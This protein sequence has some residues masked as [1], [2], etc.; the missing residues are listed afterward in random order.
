MLFRD[1]RS[2]AERLNGRDYNK[3][4][5]KMQA[6][7]Y[8]KALESGKF[9][10][11]LEW[12]YGEDRVLFQRQRYLAAVKAFSQ[13]FGERDVQILSAPG[14]T[15]IGGNHTDHQHGRVVA[16]SVDM[17][18]LAVVSK[19]EG[20]EILLQSEGYPIN[21][22]DLRELEILEAEKNKSNSL[23]R[24][25][26]ARFSQLGYQTGAFVAYTTSNVLKGS[27]LSSSAAFEVLVGTILSELY[28][29][30]AIPA[31]EIAK[32][33]QYAE[34]VYFGK[35]SGLLDQTASA[36]G[37]FVAIDFQNPEVPTV[38]KISL[39]IEKCGYALCIVDTGGSHADL[40]P[41]YAAIPTEMGSVARA[42]GAEVLRDVDEQRF[43]A[44]LSLL[45]EQC[46]DRAVLRAIHF[47]EENA[48]AKQQAE[49]LKAGDMP[50]FLQ[51]VLASGN[52]SFQ[53]L[54]NVYSPAN[55]Q[56]QGIS[57]ALA[58]C[59]RLLERKGAW[60]VHGG[61]FAGT[62]QA[63]V[64]LELVHEFQEV[65]EQVFGAG[66]FHQLK[67][68]PCGAYRLRCDD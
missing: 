17:D 5:E 32:I 26:C 30:G 13:Q 66:S 20:T 51:T 22:M 33:G 12:L 38:E 4:A 28:N 23:L 6:Q 7:K 35:P 3:G 46:G 53:Y 48:R 41:D 24:G 60:R 11:C 54:Q 45:R 31:V 44:N 34:N 58:I 21:R 67:I 36:V 47:F 27:G 14:R 16:A 1:D 39:E 42:L 19:T 49:L 64:P 56:Q 63:Y 29:Q 59:H 55:P 37:G 68:R 52:S 65:M 50:R 18:V 9:D 61:G 15:E 57:L 40:T 25:I 43:Y 2:S 62:V 8:I 10:R